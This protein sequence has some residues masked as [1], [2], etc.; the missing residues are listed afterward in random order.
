MPAWKFS[1]VN[2]ETPALHAAVC[3]AVLQE[4]M[5]VRGQS[6]IVG[7]SGGADS[8]ALLHVLR[9]LA[10]QWDLRLTAAHLNHCL[11]GQES[12]RDQAFVRD[13][14]AGWGIPLLTE[15][16]A[17]GPLA[18]R[19]GCSVEEC[20]RAER[21]A[22]FERCAAAVGADCIATAHTLSDS[23][24]TALLNLTRGTALRGLCGIPPVR[25]TA[26]GRKVI[27]P[28]IDC[29]RAQVE[30]YCAEHSLAFVTDST[31][32]TEAYTR[33]RLRHRVIP[34]L[35][36]QNPAFA[37]SM[38]GTMQALRA[39]ADYLDE[40]ARE[41][42]AA[43]P[44]GANRYRRAPL[45]DL[46]PP[47]RRRVLLLLL[48]QRGV[49]VSRLRL[50][51]LEQLLWQGGKVQLS[52]GWFCRCEGEW[53]EFLAAQ[54]ARS[55]SKPF[56][57]QQLE[58]KPPFSEAVFNVFSDKKLRIISQE[59]EGFEENRNSFK[60]V[61]KNAL[62]YDKIKGIVI[63]RQRLPGDS[64]ALAGRGCTKSLKKLFNEAGL[65]ERQRQRTLVLADAQGLLWVEGFGAAQT[66]Q[67]GGQTR[68][69][70]LLEVLEG[71]GASAAEV[72]PPDF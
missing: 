55:R 57:Q 9:A 29:T 63:L 46:A 20:A 44:A 65:T 48:Q 3:T 23:V 33:N 22:F 24:E 69:V 19:Q 61:L 13:L 40:L 64:I 30:A 45:R 68:G 72:K 4:Q 60:K 47:L 39:D 56:A 38:G 2:R 49:P 71:P 66:V 37:R 5:L 59:Y 21:Y 58:L 11:R 10:P 12:E 36:E 34:L 70:L 35:Q 42:L 6:C 53:L 54:D 50:E 18:R 25:F 32:L 1:A 15:A 41:A 8:V 28:L 62:D 52:G 27:R 14:C 26:Q 67:P 16:V 17:V 31:N 51:Q 43:L 7:V